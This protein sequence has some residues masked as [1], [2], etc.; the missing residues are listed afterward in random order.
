[1]QCGEVAEGP[2]CLNLS[3]VVEVSV[4]LNQMTATVCTLRVKANLKR[5]PRG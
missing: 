1:M 5:F 3:T 2:A 4:T